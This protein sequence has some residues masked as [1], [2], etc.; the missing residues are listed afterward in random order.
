RLRVGEAHQRVGL[1]PVLYLGAYNQYIQITFPLFVEAFGGD[2]AAALPALLS[3]VKVIFLDVGL[4]LD[5]YFHAATEQLRG[6]NDELQRA[7]LLYGQAQQREERFRHLLSHEVRGG[8]AAVITTLDD[9]LDVARPD[10]D[11]GAVEQLEG[12]AR[13]CW[14]LSNLLT[15]MLTTA[16]EEGGP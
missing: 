16:R 2:A 12:A 1:P 7:L 15:E 9:C 14:S 10:L 3:L 6:R 8:L 5:T 11:P 13:R 4:A